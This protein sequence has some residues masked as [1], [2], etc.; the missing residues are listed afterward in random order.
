M[1]CILWG[2]IGFLSL[3]WT[4]GAALLAQAVLWSSRRMSDGPALSLEAAVS[5]V[6]VPVWLSPW[7]DPSSLT[8]IVHMVQGVLGSFSSVLPTMGMVL[9]WLIPAIWITWG[10]G[11]LL[12]VGAVVVGT[13]ILQ[14]F[15]KSWQSGNG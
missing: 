6:I 9:G 2:G 12:L 13:P 3:L 15:N 10:L 7:F 5:T 11:M 14:R 8:N 1:K 4:S